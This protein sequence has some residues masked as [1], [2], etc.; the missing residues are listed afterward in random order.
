MDDCKP[1]IC[2]RDGVTCTFKTKTA[3]ID[4]CGN[5]ESYVESVNVQQ[6]PIYAPC[7]PRNTGKRKR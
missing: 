7:N 1:S 6:P 5:M 2:S 3:N 4:K